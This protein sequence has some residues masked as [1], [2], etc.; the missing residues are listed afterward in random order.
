MLPWTI[1]VAASLPARQISRNFDTA[2][3]GFDVMLT[4]VL[5]ATG[6]FA[7]RRSRYLSTAVTAAAVL[8]AILQQRTIHRSEVVAR[9]L[10]AAL[11][12]RIIEQAK[13]VIAERLQISA[14]NADAD[15]ATDRSPCGGAVQISSAR[16]SVVRFRHGH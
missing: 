12:S 5:A 1:C 3:A 7:L 2:W 11:T 4:G 16:P 9:R 10:Q 8:I 6:Y 14:D 13:G 15:A